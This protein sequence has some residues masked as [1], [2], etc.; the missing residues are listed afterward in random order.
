M[1]MEIVNRDR[2]TGEDRAG[3]VP[4][5]KRAIIVDRTM[6]A[7]SMR[8]MMMR[9]GGGDVRREDRDLVPRW[10]SDSARFQKSTGLSR[11]QLIA[12]PTTK[13]R[14]DATRTGHRLRRSPSRASLP[15]PFLALPAAKAPNSVAKIQSDR[16]I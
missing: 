16:T 12:H 8:T 1:A 15:R 11:G 13:E 5:D 9:R 7:L 10:I 14:F 2:S 4:S 3:D 6:V